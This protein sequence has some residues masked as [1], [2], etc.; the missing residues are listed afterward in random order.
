MNKST[1]FIIKARKVQKSL[2]HSQKK[3]EGISTSLPCIVHNC[4]FSVF[5]SAHHGCQKYKEDKN[6]PE[7]DL[8]VNREPDDVS[9]ISVE[10]CICKL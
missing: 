3:V 1:T 7:I 4:F 2:F 10:D 5:T 9:C 8:A 6:N